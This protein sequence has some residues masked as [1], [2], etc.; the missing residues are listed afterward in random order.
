MRLRRFFYYHW[1]RG[2]IR[3]LCCVPIFH[4]T[5]ACTF[6]TRNVVRAI[7][8]LVGC[9]ISSYD[10]ALAEARAEIG[11]SHGLILKLTSKASAQDD[12]DL[13]RAGLLA[14]QKKSP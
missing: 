12:N 5:T 11:D 13:W 10:A 2:R 4:V 9:G 8:P 14:D 6:C 3:E 7:T 1:T